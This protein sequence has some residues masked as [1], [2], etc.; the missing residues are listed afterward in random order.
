MTLF[1]RKESLLEQNL[2][3]LDGIG[4]RT[5]ADIVGNAPEIETGLHGEIPAET[6]YKH[7]IMSK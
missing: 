5:L 3:N 1:S 4:S 7:I 6:A 2:G